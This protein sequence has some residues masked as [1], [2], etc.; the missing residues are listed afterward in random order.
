MYHLGLQAIR[1]IIVIPV[2]RIIIVGPPGAK[3][4]RQ[5]DSAGWYQ[6]KFNKKAE[7]THEGTTT[8]HLLPPTLSLLP[9][10]SF[11]SRKSRTRRR[12]REQTDIFQIFGESIEEFLIFYEIGRYRG[13]F[14][15]PGGGLSFDV[16]LEGEY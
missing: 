16:R 2:T 11:L 4:V 10:S 9:L 1:G 13:D 8:T 15:T 6:D 5:T 3:F 12:R 7:S 14:L